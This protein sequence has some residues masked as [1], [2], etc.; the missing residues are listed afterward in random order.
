MVLPLQGYDTYLAFVPQ[1]EAPSESLNIPS[2]APSWWS[3][4][5]LMWWALLTLSGYVLSVPSAFSLC[6]SRLSIPFALSPLSRSVFADGFRHVRAL[7]LAEG[8]LPMRWVLLVPIGFAEAPP[9]SPYTGPGQ[10]PRFCSTPFGA[11]AGVSYFSCES[12]HMYSWRS[13]CWFT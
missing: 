5:P 2:L 10:S 6:R 7:A 9:V 12:F 1:F 3:P 4:C 8:H 13:F 11:Q